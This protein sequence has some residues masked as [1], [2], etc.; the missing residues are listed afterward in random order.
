MQI[1]SR[2]V[3]VGALCLFALA[4]AA[5]IT[6]I[7]PSEV[8][9]NTEEFMN[10][11]GANLVGSV[12]TEVVFDGVHAVEPSFAATDHL[13]VF[14]PPSVTGE[15]G[16]HTLVVRSLDDGGGVRLHGPVSFTVSAPQNEGGPPL[17]S[18]PEIVVG[19]AMS[20]NGGIVTYEALAY[21]ADGD[22]P[23]TCTPASGDTFRLGV[24]IVSCSATNTSG[25]TV[26]S[27]FAIVTDTTPPVVTVPDNI[28]TDNPVVTFTASATD[29]LDGTL[30]VTCFPASGS[31]FAQGTT[32]VRCTATDAHANRGEA[33]FS[34]FVSG[35]PPA[36]ILPDDI[37]EEATGPTGAVA[38]FI[39]TSADETPVNCT[40]ASGSTFPLGTT[41]VTCTATNPSGT[42]TGSFTVL[43]ID[44]TPPVITAPSLVEV[45]ATSPAGALV[46]YVVTAHDLVDGDVPV[47]C[48][49]VSGS[50]F[51]FGPTDVVCSAADSRF[52]GDVIAFQ[53]IVQDT[54]APA[55]TQIS[56]T[57]GALWP[58]NHQMVNVTVSATLTDAV[59]PSPTWKI[60][61]VSSNQ[62][63]QGTGDGDQP[64]DWVITGPTTLQ[65]R[66]ERS[67]GKERI[68]TIT[69]ETRDALGNAGTAIVVV[70]VADT[71]KRAAA[72]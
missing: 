6:R 40:P 69:I 39:A 44:T 46:T 54:T 43:V 47:S 49:L 33:T 18:L 48:L 32:R 45:E 28:S 4:A 41:S 23:I 57:P 1:Q 2:A 24:T 36:L 38:S 65:L 26:G 64:V 50:Q 35:G 3:L 55:V 20:P 52:N 29:N 56:A 21:D 19:E 70:R 62:P 10:V 58:P 17:L 66:S 42:S 61:S 53:V 14:I 30:P 63:T 9:L 15:A 68:Y 51:P 22:V 5:D 59:D 25:T 67:H 12:S 11:Y 34:V 27:F 60:V 71:K 8:D 37:V 31:T 72:H 13:I 7:S 16:Q